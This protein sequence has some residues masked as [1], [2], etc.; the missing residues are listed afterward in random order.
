MTGVQTC[1]LPICADCASPSGIGRRAFGAP[2]EG[3]HRRI[4]LAQERPHHPD[5]ILNLRKIRVMAL[6]RDFRSRHDVDLITQKRERRSQL[7]LQFPL[8]RRDMRNGLPRNFRRE[9][10]ELREIG[11]MLGQPD[12]HDRQ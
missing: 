7:P 4:K 5:S 12:R 2:G 6:R 8:D 9:R 3:P 10:G 11:S 1:A